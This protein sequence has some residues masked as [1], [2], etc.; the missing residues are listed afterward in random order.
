MSIGFVTSDASQILEIAPE[1]AKAPAKAVSIGVSVEAKG[2]SV[3][4]RPSGPY[5][6]EGPVLRVDS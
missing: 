5:V 2:G 6:F 3:T 4:G 1:A